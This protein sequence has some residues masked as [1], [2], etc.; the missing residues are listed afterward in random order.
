[1]KA[2]PVVYAIALLF[3]VLTGCA[4]AQ[5]GNTDGGQVVSGILQGIGQ[6]LSGLC[7]NNIVKLR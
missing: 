1:M 7:A 5:N 3:L 6:G 2:R 4:L